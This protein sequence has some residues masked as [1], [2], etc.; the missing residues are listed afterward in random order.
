MSA[1]KRPRTKPWPSPTAVNLQVARFVGKLAVLWYRIRRKKHLE[2]RVG[3]GIFDLLDPETAE[4]ELRGAE[5]QCRYYAHTVFTWPDGSSD[6]LDCNTPAHIKR[7][8]ESGRFRRVAMGR[9]FD[10][11]GINAAAESIVPSLMATLVGHVDGCALL[12]D[13]SPPPWDLD[14]TP[15]QLAALVAEVVKSNT[16][17]CRPETEDAGGTGIPRTRPFGGANLEF[18]KVLESF[19]HLVDNSDVIKSRAEPAHARSGVYR[20]IVELR[21]RRGSISTGWRS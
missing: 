20:R 13:E 16:S 6:G 2:R 3:R 21:G 14:V 8:A 7:L 1:L 15:D 9:Q 12:P 11:P 18:G 5:Q 17:A 4:A 10:E 19:E